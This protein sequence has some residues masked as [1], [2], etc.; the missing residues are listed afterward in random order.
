MIEF[1]FFRKNRGL[2]KMLILTSVMYAGRKSLDFFLHQNIGKK[3]L[4]ILLRKTRGGKFFFY[5]INQDVI[6]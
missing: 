3:Q 2:K 6:F 5:I 4:K 1:F